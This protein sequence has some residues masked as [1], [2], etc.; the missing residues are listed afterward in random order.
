MLS[1]EETQIIKDAVNDFFARAGQ[2]GEI[3]SFSLK[4]EGEN[5]ILDINIRSNDA[6]MLIGKQGMVLSDIQ[7]LLRKIIKKKLDRE[8]FLN[9]DIDNYKKKKEDY[10]RDLAEE[11][12]NEVLTTKK[13]KELLL[14]SPFD[15]RIVHLELARRDNLIVESIGEGEERR[16]IIKPKE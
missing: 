15:R 16:I 5:E 14:P 6:Q 11:A 9:L 1:Q 3:K 7:L 4:Q 2:D 12:A 13:E 8:I 10:L